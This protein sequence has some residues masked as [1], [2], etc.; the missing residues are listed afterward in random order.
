MTPTAPAPPDLDPGANFAAHQVSG[1]LSI[2]R[3][4]SGGTGTVR[5]AG[6]I[7]ARNDPHF[8]VR[9]NEVS[10]LALWLEA[11]A[12]VVARGTASD[13]APVV[14]SVEPAWEEG[15]LRLTIRPVRGRPL[16]TTT[17]RRVGTGGGFGALTRNALTTLDTRGTFRADVLDPAHRPVGWLQVRVD[18]PVQP[19]LFQGALPPDLPSGGTAEVVALDS[20]I[21]WIM[22][23]VIDV[24][25]GTSGGRFDGDHR[26]R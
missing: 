2:D 1:G 23:R 22:D 12:D 8:V 26:P 5:P 19:R 11:P 4:P 14:E 13:S 21:D 6:W 17:F 16:S 10:V 9:V 18:D 3:W 20:E 15:A 24:Y 25:R 7:R